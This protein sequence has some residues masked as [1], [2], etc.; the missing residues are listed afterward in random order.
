M[1]GQT[2]LIEFVPSR[3]GTPVGS[4]RPGSFYWQLAENYLAVTGSLLA[5]PGSR[6][7]LPVACRQCQAVCRQFQAARRQLQA[8]LA[9]LT[10]R[11]QAVIIQ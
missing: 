2:L 6:R 3:P 1:N 8:L 9:E 11:R 7:Q 5:V 10:L 4:P